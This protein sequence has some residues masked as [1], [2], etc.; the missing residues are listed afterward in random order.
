MQ[1]KALY[2]CGCAGPCFPGGMFVRS[3]K[4]MPSATFDSACFIGIGYH[5]EDV[6]GLGK[7]SF[8]GAANGSFTPAEIEVYDISP[9]DDEWA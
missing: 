9:F 6:L 2:C 8:T 3:S 7:A 1:H 4:G 5:Y